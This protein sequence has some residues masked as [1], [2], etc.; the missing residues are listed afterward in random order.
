MIFLIHSSCTSYY[1]EIFI[2]Q[3]F[4]F[5]I[6]GQKFVHLSP[7]Y[8]LQLDNNYLLLSLV[9]MFNYKSLSISELN[10][11][12]S[13]SVMKIYCNKELRIFWS[14]EKIV[15]F[16][17]THGW[18]HQKK[19]LKHFR[20]RNESKICLPWPWKKSYGGL[21]PKSNSWYFFSSKL[22]YV[23]NDS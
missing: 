23:R 19:Q 3:Y 10:F 22:L 5:I 18:T 21:P 16:L 15:V 4:R 7:K 13:I 8:D 11:L 2:F 9:F 1:R 17:W 14:W 6:L 20:L 12:Q